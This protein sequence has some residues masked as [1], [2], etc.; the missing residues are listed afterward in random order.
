MG[1]MFLYNLMRTA[2]FPVHFA[3]SSTIVILKII[4]ISLIIHNIENNINFFNYFYFIGIVKF[5]KN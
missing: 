1:K 3:K 2:S 5:C 4:L